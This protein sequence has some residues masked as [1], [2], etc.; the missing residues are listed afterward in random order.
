MKV[1]YTTRDGRMTFELEGVSQTDLF[2]QI[3]MVQEVFEDTICSNKDSS[4]DVVNFVVRHVKDN[5][6]YELQCVDKNKPALRY[7]KKKFGVHKGKDG[8][9]FPKGG[10]VKY[11]K[12]KNAELDL[13]TGE[14]VKEKD[15]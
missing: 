2:R 12:E 14:V 1:L 5:D 4:S 11:N 3:A 9:M 6:F 8:T 10:W 13:Q 15:E 7:A